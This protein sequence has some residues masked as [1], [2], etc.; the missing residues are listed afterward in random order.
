MKRRFVLR[1]VY[2]KTSVVITQPG[3][4]QG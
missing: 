4:N 3:T 2:K 1:N